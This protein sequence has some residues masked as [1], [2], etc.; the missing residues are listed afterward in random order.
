MKAKRSRRA[1]GSKGPKKPTE[2]PP[3]GKH[4]NDIDTFQ[5]VI[6]NV[7]VVKKN[8]YFVDFFFSPYCIV[9]YF[10]F[11]SIVV[12]LFL[13]LTRLQELVIKCCSI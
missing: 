1:S 12:F 3:S 6:L 5:S 8:C 10:L 2:G 4:N 13:E 11:G 7:S 9:Q